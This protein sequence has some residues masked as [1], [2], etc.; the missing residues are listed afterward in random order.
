MAK[1]KFFGFSNAKYTFAFEFELYA[2]QKRVKEETVKVDADDE[3]LAITEATGMLQQKYPE[4]S[5]R[6]TQHFTRKPR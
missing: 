4:L 2:G 1:K 3:A 5:V 6:Y